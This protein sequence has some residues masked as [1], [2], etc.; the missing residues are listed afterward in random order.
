[1]PREKYQAEQRQIQVQVK[2]SFLHRP[3]PN[4]E[5]S[6]DRPGQSGSHNKDGNA[7]RCPRSTKIH[8]YGIIPGHVS[9][10]TL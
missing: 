8:W 4:A 9:P 10:Q 1:M 6:D 5:W 7:S 3:H 2:G